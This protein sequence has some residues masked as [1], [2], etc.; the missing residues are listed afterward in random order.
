M[1]LNTPHR[2]ALQTLF[3]TLVFV[4]GKLTPKPIRAADAVPA[5]PVA[6]R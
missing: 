1:N 2:R 3:A 4:W 6:A 5:T